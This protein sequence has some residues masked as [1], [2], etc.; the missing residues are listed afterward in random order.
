MAEY[1]MQELN[2]PNEEGKRIFYPRIKII[3]TGGLRSH[4]R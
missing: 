4:R 3:R 1:N 2:L